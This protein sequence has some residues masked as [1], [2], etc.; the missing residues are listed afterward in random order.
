MREI[1]ENSKTSYRVIGFVDMGDMHKGMKIH[2]IPILGSVTDLPQLVSFYGIEDIL[3][4]DSGSEVQRH[5]GS[6]R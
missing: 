1:H 6:Y 4:A 2:G 3:I 5:I